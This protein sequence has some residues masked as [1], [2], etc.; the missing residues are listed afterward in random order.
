MDILNFKDELLIHLN[1]Q[2]GITPGKLIDITE[3]IKSYDLQ[4]N[5]YYVEKVVNELFAPKDRS[6]KLIHSDS[7]LGPYGFNQ[8]YFKRN[9][10]PPV[11]A[12]ITPEGKK[13]L[14]SLTESIPVSN[15]TH[16]NS[17]NFHGNA[18][19][20]SVLTNNHLEGGHMRTHTISPTTINKTENSPPN[21]KPAQN[22]DR[23]I[24]IAGVF[25]AIIVG[26]ITCYQSCSKDKQPLNP[27]P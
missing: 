26:V 8:S 4:R 22:W 9:V 20:V 14:K 15:V 23:Y 11:M 25:V 10:V 27:C 3:F 2:D 7:N 18:E 6:P 16:D 19:N 5:F 21:R 13:Y 24:A 17:V 12:R 1:E